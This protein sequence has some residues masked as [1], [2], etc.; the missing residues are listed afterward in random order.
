MKRVYLV[1]EERVNKIV[2]FSI[3]AHGHINPTLEVVKELVSRGNEVYYYAYNNFKEKIEATG[4]KFI[5]FDG[6]DD[7]FK[8]TQKELVAGSNDLDY[9]IDLMVN[10]TL[11]IDEIIFREIEKIKPD[12]IVSDNLTIWGKMIAL[13]LDIPLV[14]SNAS[15]V[16]NEHSARILRYSIKDLISVIASIP[17]A[18]K[19]IKKLRDRGYPIKNVLDVMKN[20]KNIHTIVYTSSEFQPFSHTFSDKYVFVGPSILPAKSSIEKTRDKLIY[21]SMGTVNNDLSLFYKNCIEAFKDSEYQVI[22]SVGNSVELDEFKVNSE[23]ISIFNKVDQIAVLK[24]ADVFI[25]HG[26]MNSVSESLYNKVPLV[27][28]PQIIE[29]RGVAERVKQ[30][31]A[32]RILYGITPRHIRSAVNKVI[33]NVKYYKKAEIISEGFKRC[34]GAKGAA[35]K[36]LE[37][38]G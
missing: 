34:T 38:C 26:G 7:K 27:M 33:N 21:I 19:N 2:F 31:G 17:K 11:D 18:N 24:K 1:V 14:C 25:S 6:Y 28:F 5:A 15:F 32:G 3:P 12:C 35:N 10:K 8:I 37:M 9:F 29:Q 22:I 23:N 16:F 36:I 4:A 20:H 13:K 30:L